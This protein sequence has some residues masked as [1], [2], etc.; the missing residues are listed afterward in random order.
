MRISYQWL[1][2]HFD[3]PLPPP[4]EVAELLIFHA[5][6]VESLEEHAGDT[7]LDIKVLPDRAHDC[8]S[9]RGIA[10]ELARILG[11]NIS[12][13]RSAA[14]QGVGAGNLSVLIQDSEL[15]RRYVGAVVE[16][17]K[18]GPSPAWL[19]ERLEAVG[20]RSI[21]NVVDATNFLMLDIGQPLHAFDADKLAKDGGQIEIAVRQAQEGEQITT[22]DKR[23]VKLDTGTLVIAD[24]SGPLAIAGIKGGTKAEVDAHTMN[25]VL[26]SA[27]FNPTMVR[28]AS[29]R[30]GIRTDSSKRFENELT[31]E[32]A[33]E[34]MDRLAAL[35]VEVAGGSV[36]ARVD[37]YPKPVAPYMLTFA[38]DDINRVLGTAF[39]DKDIEGYLRRAGLPHKQEADK[40]VLTIPSERLDLR[41]PE[42]IAEEI[43]RL[44]GYENIPAKALVLAEF[45]PRPNKGYYYA[46]K[47]RNVLTSLGFSEVQTYTFYDEG[48]VALANPLASDKSHLRESLSRGLMDA[49]VLNVRNAPLLGLEEVKIFEIGSVFPSIEGEHMALGIAI[50]IPAGGKKKEDMVR[51]RFMEVKVTLE[52]ELGIRFEDIPVKEKSRELM[53]QTTSVLHINLSYF[54]VAAPEPA[55][56]GDVLV[57]PKTE[58]RYKSFSPYPFMVRDVAVFVPP[59]MTE[60]AVKK[61]ITDAAG[62]LVVHGPDRFDRFEKKNKETGEIEKVSYAFR[63]VFQSPERTLTDED[64]NAAM[65]RV[66]KALNAQ[67]GFEV[68]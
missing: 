62:E 60:D 16:G 68:R 48:P 34:A 27:N 5:F 53:T 32:L 67:E 28:K 37:E 12:D 47:I 1:E 63:T 35:I 51:E 2:D 52:K 65:V 45:K 19:R 3:T 39:T 26:E 33:G 13:K 42:D 6:E 38:T 7:I 61:I 10:R 36:V 11:T 14:P 41:I 23:E 29:G 54:V 43:G 56:Y 21:N 58:M 31:P 4:K 44:Y 59:L 20:Q 50:D 22:L 15:C 46:N 66:T 40:F 9:H 18:V 17:V 30:L 55:G 8:L 64:A 49:L 57:P 25:L 24:S